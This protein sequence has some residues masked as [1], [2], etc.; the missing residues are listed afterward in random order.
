MRTTAAI[1]DKNGQRS[2]LDLSTGTTSDRLSQ[3]NARKY[4]LRGV[5]LQCLQR[6]YWEWLP[7]FSGVPGRINELGGGEGAFMDSVFIGGEF[8]PPVLVWRN[9]PRVGP[10]T[11]GETKEFAKNLLLDFRVPTVVFVEVV[12]PRERFVR[13]CE[14]VWR[15]SGLVAHFWCRIC[16]RFVGSFCASLSLLLFSRPQRRQV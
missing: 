3:I 13:Y 1:T 8:T 15:L 10:S 16:F 4:V 9:D 2:L 5:F 12:A 11:T 14:M 7:A 6:F